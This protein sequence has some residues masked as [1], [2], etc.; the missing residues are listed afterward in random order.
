MRELVSIQGGQCGNQIGAKFWE[1]HHRDIRNDTG[2]I[3]RERIEKMERPKIMD[4][5]FWGGDSTL[6]HILFF[7]FL[8]VIY[9]LAV[10]IDCAH[11]YVIV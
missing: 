2:I 6:E 9:V 4:T 3:L 11:T 10:Y 7:R 5:F 8:Y 1:V